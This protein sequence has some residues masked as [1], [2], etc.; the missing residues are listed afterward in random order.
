MINPWSHNDDMKTLSLSQLTHTFPDYLHSQYLQIH[1]PCVG[2]FIINEQHNKH[3]KST[4]DKSIWDDQGYR[5]AF[6]CLH[7]ETGKQT[8]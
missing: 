6:E 8:R 4:H 3:P 1:R 2:H 5:F 7:G